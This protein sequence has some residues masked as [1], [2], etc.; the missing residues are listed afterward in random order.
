MQR[1]LFVIICISLSIS[2]FSQN[3]QISGYVFDSKTEKAISNVNISAV[4]EFTGGI[5]DKEGFFSFKVDKLPAL[6]YFS[7]VGYSINQV[8]VTKSNRKKL[9]I[10]LTPEV[11]NLNEVTISAER[12]QQVKLGDTLNVIDYSIRGNRIILVAT[13]YK[14]Q[15]DQRLY[16]TD[17]D[18][19]QISNIQVERVGKQ[20]KFPEHMMPEYVFLFEDFMGDLN[21]LTRKNVLQ[22]G[23]IDDSLRI[24]SEMDY[25]SFLEF[26]FPI[27][28]IYGESLFLQNSNKTSNN[29]YRIGPDAY[30]P[31]LIKTIHD[32]EGVSRYMYP[33][34]APKTIIKKVSAP[35]IKQKDEILIFDFF[36]NH[37]EYFDS[38][39]QSK[40]IVPIDFQN[41]SYRYFLSLFEEEALNQQEFNQ[42]ILMD[43]M[44]GKLYALFHKIG[45]K[46]R[47]LEIDPSNGNVNNEIEIPDMPNVNRI[48]VHNN[49]IYFTYNVKI[50]P[51]YTNLYRMPIK[52]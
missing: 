18:G 11:T 44:T 49:V 34:G 8:R 46:A 35:I 2:S 30:R 19:E 50:Y 21:L 37:I 20:I 28:A 41:F 27:K 36:N 43:K 40:K 13:P 52:Q 31:H 6:L 45:K 9:R 51:Y 10:L 5:T 12:I 38:I 3:H 23:H 14:N 25:Y 33:T 32:P 1:S 7:H 17:L 22:I 24:T 42:E 26:V 47:L 4:G 15:F 39:G 29:T 48:K 16:L